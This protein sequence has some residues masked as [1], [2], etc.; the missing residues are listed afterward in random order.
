MTHYCFLFRSAL[1]TSRWCGVGGT[2]SND[3][4]FCKH[5]LLMDEIRR[6][7]AD[8]VNIP[9]LK[10]LMLLMVQKSG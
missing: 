6:S 4:S 5:L 9:L 8:R 10:G 1:G 7:P 2:G 3:P